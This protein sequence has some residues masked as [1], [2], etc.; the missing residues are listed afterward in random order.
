MSKI[1][2][3]GGALIAPLPP[4]MVSCGDM[5]KSNIMTV[6][7]TGIINTIPPKTYISVRP[8]RYS[9]NIIKESGEFVINLPTEKI[10]KA[11]DYCGCRT[12]AKEDKLAKCGLTVTKGVK[13]DAPMVDQSP[14]NLECKVTD[15]VHLGSHDMFI[16]D[17]VGVN[18]DE[19]LLDEKGKLHLSK[20]GLCAYAHGEYFALG[21]QIGD[22]GFSVRRK[23]V[24]K[25]RNQQAKE[26]AKKNGKNSK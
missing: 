4:V 1:K 22:F 2:W 20:A 17:I 15:I 3:K 23:S 9:Y 7:W 6:A 21:K 14:V 19:S 11:V 8:S 12:G 16:A 10:V 24:Q 25:R 18:V 13:I 5:E 26:G